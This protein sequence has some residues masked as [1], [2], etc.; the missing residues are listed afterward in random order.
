M[1]PL[2]R[3]IHRCGHSLSPPNC[4]IKENIDRLVQRTREGGAEIVKYLKTG[5]PIC[6]SAAQREM[7][8]AILQ[9]KKKI[10]PCAAY[11]QGS[12]ESTTYSS[13][14]R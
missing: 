5:A 7:V 14:C 2:P 8:E 10:F 1:V 4:W 3:S 12:M 13:A 11:L 9:D 6:A